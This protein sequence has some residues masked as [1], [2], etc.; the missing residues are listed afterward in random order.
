M[1]SVSVRGI[2]SLLNDI[3]VLL[4]LPLDDSDIWS[5]VVGGHPLHT[6]LDLVW[7]HALSAILLFA[8]CQ[9]SYLCKV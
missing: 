4:H 1:E 9:L 2:Q 7:V 8:C 6:K 3:I 5:T